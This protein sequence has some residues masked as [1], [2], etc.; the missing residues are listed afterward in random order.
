M[1]VL[2]IDVGG[3]NVKILATGKKKSR[4]FA[5]GPMMDPKQMVERVKKLAGDWKYDAISIGYPGVVVEGRIVKE[6]YNLAPGWPRFNFEAA[7]K[8]PVK[9]INDAAM[10]ALGSYQGGL[11]LFIG[12]GTGLGSALIT[13]G[14]VIPME[15]G[16]LS[17]R[18]GSYAD[19]LGRDGLKRR[20]KKKWR[21]DL[22]RLVA[23]WIQALNPDDIVLGGGNAKKLEKLPD[24]C[25]LGGN[26]HAF[27][28]GFRLWKM[29][30]DRE[31]RSHA[32]H[33][34]YVESA[35]AQGGNPR[36]RPPKFPASAAKRSH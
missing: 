24:G 11:L 14:V 4:K 17:Y 8:C 22:A 23:R 26:T 1:N 12:L 3:T 36:R 20:G 18:N 35:G 9:I 32:L 6:P 31:N 28:G 7:F 29:A 5:S 13:H 10:Q 19:Y 27:Q 25:R 2:V 34:S 16:R 33:A 30:V 15:L 21:R